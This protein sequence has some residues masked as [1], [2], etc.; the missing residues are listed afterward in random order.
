MKIE[1]ISGSPRTASLTH[2]LAL[3]LHRYLMENTDHEIGLIDIRENGLPPIQKVFISADAAPAPYKELAA[4]MFEAQAFILVSPEYNGSYTPDLKNLLDHFPKQGRKTFALATGS[5]GALGG[6]RAAMQLQQLV[7][8]L[9]GIGS[10][11]LLI[12]PQIDKKMDAEGHLL[13]ESFRTSIDLFIKE[14]VWLAEHVAEEKV[15]AS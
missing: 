5:P 11:Y 15:M 1:I 14:F 12:T 8:A 4:R 2:R 6:I 7:Y 9:F 3:H 10:P 13:D